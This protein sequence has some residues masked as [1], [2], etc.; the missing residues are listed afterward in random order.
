MRA[1]VTSALV[2]ELAGLAGFTFSPERCED[3]APQ[4][5]WLLTEARRIE[6]LPLA[7][8]EPVSTF[9]PAEGAAAVLADGG[10][11]HE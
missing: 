7:G 4:L 10:A 6:A 2:A 8:L 9:R 3:L 5:E 1:L 11:P